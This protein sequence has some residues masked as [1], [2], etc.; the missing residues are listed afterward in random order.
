M[1]GQLSMTVARR[2]GAHIGCAE[3]SAWLLQFA[4]DTNPGDGG[5]RQ[6]KVYWAHGKG[7]AKIR[8]GTD[9]AFKRCVRHLRKYFPRNPEGLCA[10]IEHEATGHWPAEKIIES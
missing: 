4:V 5:A 9:G 1:A 2:Q 3:L 8:W 10:N 6:L 7:A